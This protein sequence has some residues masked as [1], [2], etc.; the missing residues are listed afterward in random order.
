[1]A[2][3][4]VIITQTL[5]IPGEYLIISGDTIRS[6]FVVPSSSISDWVASVGAAAAVIVVPLMVR[7]VPA[8]R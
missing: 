4:E 2:P 1:M 8:V 6:A 7:L 5:V 3:A